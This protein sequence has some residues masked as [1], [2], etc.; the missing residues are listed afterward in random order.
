MKNRLMPSALFIFLVSTALV[1]AAYA[2]PDQLYDPTGTYDNVHFSW[3]EAGPGQSAVHLRVFDQ[4][5]GNKVVDQD[6]ILGTS[7]DTSLPRPGTYDWQLGCSG[8][9]TSLHTFTI[10]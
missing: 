7:Y 6:G 3:H 8:N 4:T 9:W 1:I 2:C 10:N 5:T